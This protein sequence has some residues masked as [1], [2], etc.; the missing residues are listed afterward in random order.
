ML[1][2]PSTPP[3]RAGSWDVLH[4]DATLRVWALREVATVAWFDAPTADQ[5]RTLQRLA[6]QRLVKHP[7]GLWLYQIVV[8]GTPRF[9]DDV[10]EEVDRI[11]REETFSLGSAHVILAPGLA[12]AAARA[13]LST[14]LL[15]R[16]NRLPAKVFGDVESAAPWLVREIGGGVQAG[17]LVEIGQAIVEG[18]R[19]PAS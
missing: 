8:R 13:F 7:R 19:P 16:K 2:Q 11:T 12:G 5:L 15:M 9:T 10:R 4:E 6:K 14:T 18:G 1:H 17:E 3:K